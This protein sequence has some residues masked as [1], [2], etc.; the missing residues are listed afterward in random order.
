MT[1]CN[2]STL[3]FPDCKNK[4]VQASF[5]GGEVTSDGGL[6]LRQADRK[7]G[8]TRSPARAMQEVLVEQLIA[9]AQAFDTSQPLGGATPL[10][11]C[12]ARARKPARQEQWGWGRWARK[13]N[14]QQ[15]LQLNNN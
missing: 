10:G 14:N 7:L 15:P 8:L 9:V 13:P 4:K 2:Q 1:H 11:E 3:R 6:L 5:D 12:G